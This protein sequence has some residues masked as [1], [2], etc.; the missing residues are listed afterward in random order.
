MKEALLR[1]VEWHARATQGWDHDTWH[2]GH[3]MASWVDAETW[4]ALHETF[5]RFDAADSW[6][7]LLASMDLFRRLAWEAARCMDYP[8]S[9]ALDDHVAQYIARLHAEDDLP[10]PG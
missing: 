1:M 8:Y 7:A 3:H 5:G 10:C 6:R 9:R 4:E 2:E